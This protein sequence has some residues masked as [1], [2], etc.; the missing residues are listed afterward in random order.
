[1]NNAWGLWGLFTSAFISAT[2]LPG[3]S[4]AL[5]AW[6]AH[7]GHYE[8]GL[9]LAVAT[10]GNTLGGMT[11]WGIGRWLARRFPADQ[12]TG[13]RAQAV[14]YLQRYGAPIVLLSWL[15]VVGD[16]LCVAAGWLRITWWHALIYMALGKG[17]RY[18]VIIWAV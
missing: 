7:S 1:M 3:A 15:P 18:A 16:A 10:V 6:L 12:L 11:S 2:L 4:E 5:A 9:L 8:R 17:L 14:G 13:R